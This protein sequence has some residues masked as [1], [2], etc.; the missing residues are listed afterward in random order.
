MDEARFHIRFYS[1]QIVNYVGPCTFADETVMMKSCCCQRLNHCMLPTATNSTQL[2]LEAIQE[3]A[4]LWSA[5][6]DIG[7]V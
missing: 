1:C 4:W 2:F 6:T 7:T 3:V 5:P